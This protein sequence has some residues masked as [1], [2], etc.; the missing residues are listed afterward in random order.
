[1]TAFAHAGKTS[2][3]LLTVWVMVRVMRL[4]DGVLSS[5]GAAW[6]RLDVACPTGA[7]AVDVAVRA[8]AT[9]APATGAPATRAAGIGAAAAIRARG[10]AVWRVRGRAAARARLTRG[11]GAVV[12]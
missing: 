3:A 4:T 2:T 11:A 7:V 8:A 5:A 12:A 9:R 6:R 1:M 10:R